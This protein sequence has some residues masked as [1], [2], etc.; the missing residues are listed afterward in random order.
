VNCARYLRR[1]VVGLRAPVGIFGS[2]QG[3]KACKKDVVLF[4]S[5][6]SSPRK[7]FFFY[8][9]TLRA[10]KIDWG[11][12][13]RPSGNT[14]GEEERNQRTCSLV[15]LGKVVVAGRGLAEAVSCV[16]SLV[17]RWLPEVGM[18]PGRVA[19]PK[20]REGVFVLPHTCSEI[21]TDGALTSSVASEGLAASNPYRVAAESLM[22]RGRSTASSNRGPRILRL[23]V[24]GI[25]KPSSRK[26]PSTRLQVASPYSSS[27]SSSPSFFVF[28]GPD[29][30]LQHARSSDLLR[31]VCGGAAQGTMAAR[32]VRSVNRC[33]VGE[34]RLGGGAMPAGAR[35][36]A[37]EKREG[38][39]GAEVGGW[40]FVGFSFKARCLGPC[41]EAL[42]AVQDA[43]G[44]EATLKNWGKQGGE[45]ECVCVCVCVWECGTSRG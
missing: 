44:G 31:H 38:D 13:L 36:L 2:E 15:N 40:A 1:G 16:A 7:G 5:S 23:S 17:A 6:L 14:W 30:Q 32:I 42:V 29:M 9:T 37:G 26:R 20:R 11:A 24:A 22:I 21:G 4:S 35:T 10:S 33:A 12:I 41:S 3:R 34:D 18:G 45:C 39:R 27:P 43:A 19:S 25:S 8:R 28:F